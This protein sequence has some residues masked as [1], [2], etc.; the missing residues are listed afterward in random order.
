MFYQGWFSL[1][2]R[3]RLSKYM[4]KNKGE[5]LVINW[6][7]EHRHLTS[8]C[9]FCIM[10]LNED[11]FLKV[12]SKFQNKMTTN[13]EIINFYIFLKTLKKM[14]YGLYFWQRQHKASVDSIFFRLTICLITLKECSIYFIK[15]NQLQLS[16]FYIWIYQK[17]QKKTFG[18]FSLRI[19]IVK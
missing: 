9:N 17:K 14:S 7:P 18:W 10:I 11:F 13:K 6:V 16:L 2:K 5:T 1:T 15:P 8:G 4:L 3:T 19:K 12:V